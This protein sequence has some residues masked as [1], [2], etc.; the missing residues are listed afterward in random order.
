MT[1]ATPFLWYEKDAIAAAEFYVSIFPGAKILEV[2][3]MS[4]R[5]EL[6]GRE[7][8]AFNGGPYYQPTP[9]FSI[10]VDCPTQ[11]EIDDLWTKLLAGG[12]Q[13]SRCGWL[14]DRYGLSWQVAPRAVLAQTIGNPDP[15]KAQKAMAAMMAMAKFDVAALKAAVV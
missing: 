13:E 4:A 7:Y 5:F 15:A 11:A 10:M 8:I 14:V 6:F 9:A 1:S 3:G 2:D 12:G